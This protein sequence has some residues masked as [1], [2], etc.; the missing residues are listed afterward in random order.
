MG[1]LGLGLRVSVAMS[2]GM[3]GDFGS[4]G[5]GFDSRI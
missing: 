5:S 1:P 4:D 2:E 3:Q